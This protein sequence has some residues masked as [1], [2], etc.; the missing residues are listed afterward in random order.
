MTS[1]YSK[2]P[3][4]KSTRFE[5]HHANDFKKSF[6]IPQSSGDLHFDTFGINKVVEESGLISLSD[7]I[8]QMEGDFNENCKSSSGFQVFKSNEKNPKQF[9][10][11]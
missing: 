3:T 5:K 7:P 4:S 2:L 9:I 11:L 10:E 6:N 8:S 1:K